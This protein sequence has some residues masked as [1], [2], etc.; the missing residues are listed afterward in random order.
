MFLVSQAIRRSAS[1][2]A[3]VPFITAGDPD[4]RTTVKV[5]KALDCA[6]ADVIE[7]GLPYSVPLA[8]GPIIQAAS[9]RS[10]KSGTNLDIV[11]KTFESIKEDIDAPIVLFTYYN[12]ILSRGV[13]SFM[14]DIL[15]AGIRGLLV[16]DLP[17]EES[18][19]M[20]Y[21][22]DQFNIELIFLI[23]P[24]STITRIRSIADKALGCIYLVSKTGVT[25][26]YSNAQLL[27]E[28]LVTQ[29][30]IVTSK[31][32]IVGFG[33]ANVGQIE[34]LCKLKIE[35]IVLGSVFVRMLTEETV[36]MSINKISEFCR[37]VKRIM[38]L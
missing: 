2:C 33:I 37:A 31:P 18:D 17:L 8:D 24:T 28:S 35:G 27:I 7:L 1:K 14:Q 29:V 6:G 20:I 3:L 10:L 11:L 13:L 15:Y 36:S 25:G 16:P 38:Y 9:N 34:Q 30:R 26:V 22:C 21:L 23:A 12:P 4:L 32:L 19:Y 5:I